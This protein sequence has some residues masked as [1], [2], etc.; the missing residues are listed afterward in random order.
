M[1]DGGQQDAPQIVD[2]GIDPELHTDSGI[3]V[4]STQNYTSIER[5]LTQSTQAT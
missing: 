4:R 3:W 5:Y 2:Q 1:C